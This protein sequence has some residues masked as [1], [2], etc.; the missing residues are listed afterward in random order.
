ME[1]KTQRNAEDCAESHLPE[2][3]RDRK[4]QEADAEYQRGQMPEAAEASRI[5]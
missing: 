2:P 5:N 3:S 1:R 4:A